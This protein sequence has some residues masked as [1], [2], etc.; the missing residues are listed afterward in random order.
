MEMNISELYDNLTFDTVLFLNDT[1]SNWSS[2]ENPDVASTAVVST[3]LGLLILFTIVGNISVIV[4]ITREKNLQTKGNCLVLSLAVADLLVAC[5]VM[6]LGAVYEVH[7]EWTLGREL[8]DIW[9]SC[10]VLC[11][12][13]SILHLVAIA[14]DRYW[15]VTDIDYVRQRQSWH[16]GLTILIVWIVAFCVSIAPLIGWK[17]GLHEERLLNE[18]RC[19]I[20][21]D[22]GY[23]LFATCATFYVPLVVI[24][25]L[26]WRIFRVA[27][28]RIRHKPGMRAES[29]LVS[30]TVLAS[31]VTEMTLISTTTSSSHPSSDDFLLSKEQVLKK[32]R[33]GNIRSKRE[34]K[35]AKTLTV[36]TGVFVICWLP[37]FTMALLMPLCEECQ[38]S[39]AVFSFALWLG[40]AN[41]MLN[42]II[43]TVFSPDFRMAFKQ[44]F[45]SSCRA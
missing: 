15:A 45:W 24:L 18:K 35:A 43:Y 27:R 33:R 19:L 41:S 44:L 23:Q 28:K 5:L 25:L 34:R 30:A 29:R 32:R 13:A 20:S 39:N 22:P 37:F 26:Y 38:P 9:T 16:V 2:N 36:I 12:T 42:P 1:N 10:D 11:C 14:V 17:D 7:K 31:L 8:C 3:V 6:P 4:A 40:Y 21:Q